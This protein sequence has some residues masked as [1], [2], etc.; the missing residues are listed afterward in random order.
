[1]ISRDINLIHIDDSWTDTQTE[2]L[3]SN[4]LQ[5]IDLSQYITG[6][7]AN[8]KAALVYVRTIVRVDDIK[9]KINTGVLVSINYSF[10]YNKPTDS[11][12]RMSELS[13]YSYA[14]DADNMNLYGIGGNTTIIPIVYNNKI[15]YITWDISYHFANMLPISA[16]YYYIID[17]YLLGYFK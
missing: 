1:L 14:Q 13:V 3:S 2:R 10:K 6:D 9:T 8:L 16:I 17:M 15:P 12:N 4:N 11:Y 7:L 5:N